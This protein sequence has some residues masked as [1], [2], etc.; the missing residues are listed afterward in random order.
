MPIATL[1]CLV[2]AVSDGD[3]LTARCGD[4]RPIQ[5]RLAAIDAPERRQAFGPPSRQNLARLCLRQKAT[6]QTVAR[7]AYGRTVAHV[8]CGQGDAA[9]A[10]V[11][12]G[13]A[14]VYTPRAAAYPQLAAL[15]RQAQAS[16]TGL[17]SQKRPRAPWDYRRQHPHG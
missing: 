1:L 8:R 7:D 11:R 3:T 9:T 16:H 10:Q 5:V 13:L 17:W 12:A 2:V 6:L 14:W 15:Q 4:R